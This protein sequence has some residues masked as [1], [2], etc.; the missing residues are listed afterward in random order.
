MRFF[1]ALALSDPLHF[2]EVARAADACGI[3]GVALPDHVLCPETITTPYPYDPDGR[4]PFDPSTPWPDP[5]V[6]IGAMAAVTKRLCFLT[7]VYVLPMRNP[8]LV[9]KAVG[10]AAVLS[11]NRVILGVGV[12]WMREEFAMLGEDFHTRGRRTDEAIGVL[13]ALWRGGMVEHRGRFYSFDRL[14]MS[15]A[16][17]KPVPIWIGGLTEPALRRAARL[18]DGWISMLHSLGEIQDFIARLRALRARYDRAH[19]PFDVC[20]WSVV[21]D[22][23]TFHRLED[24]GVSTVLTAPWFSYPGDPSSLDHKRRALER[25][26]E[27][28]LAKLR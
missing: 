6:A 12:G 23:D 19:E 24:A 25:F 9:A 14:Q 22:L 11:E 1:A 28:V 21:S 10:T 3:D 18:G 26:A 20:V 8:L 2:V 27:D 7:S 16:P 5:W 17:G 15:P 13:R 4:P